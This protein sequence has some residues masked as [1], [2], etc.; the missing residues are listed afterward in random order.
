MKLTPEDLRETG[1][2]RVLFDS[3]VERE[4]IP[5][6]E[7]NFRDFVALAERARRVAQ[8]NPCGLFAWLV[9]EK[10]FDFIANED[11][12]RANVRVMEFLYSPPGPRTSRIGAFDEEARRRELRAQLDAIRD[13]AAA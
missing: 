9:R 11:E 8:K 4:L 5:A 3:A 2:L 13:Q 10:R 6:G 1:R 12:A 7:R